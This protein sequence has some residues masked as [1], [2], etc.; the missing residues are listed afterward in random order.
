[1]NI[2]TMKPCGR[3]VDG[4]TACRGAAY[5]PRGHLPPRA[6]RSNPAPV[7]SMLEFWCI[8]PVKPFQ[9]GKS[10]L[11]GVLS[12]STRA[13]L[14]RRLLAGVLDVLSSDDLPAR[15]LVVSRDEEALALA[16]GRGLLGLQESGAGDLNQALEQARAHALA[17][18]AQALLVL[19]ADLPFLTVADLQG[20]YR[21][22]QMD[23]VQAVIAPSHDGGT[24]ALFL[25]PPDA[26]DFAFGVG[27]FQA[28]LAQ[29]RRRGLACRVYRSATLAR[30]LDQPA[31]LLCLGQQV[32][33]SGHG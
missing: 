30:D 28:H 13:A 2:H 11:A 21:L 25:R 18:G 1:M 23:G 14:N 16:R 9:E 3:A 20:L 22:A 4:C 29:A 6:K 26:I 24:N 7:A 5:G 10:R 27:S 31:D 17:Q 19:P 8:V 12:P 15:V 32:C 33:F